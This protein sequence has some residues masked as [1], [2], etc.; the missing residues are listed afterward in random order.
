MMQQSVSVLGGTGFV[1]R[2]LINQ[3]V[4]KGYRV[5]VP[6]RRPYGH[7][8]LGVLSG[9]ELVDVDIHDR[10]A[11]EQL[12]QGQST[13]INLVGILNEHRD[14]T[15]KKVHVDL[16]KKIASACQEAGVKRLLH[17]SALQAN[18]RAPSQYL[19]TK[20]R[21]EDYLHTEAG[22]ELAVTS[23]RPSVIFGPEDS[24]LNRF[25]SLLKKVPWLFPLACPAA[26]FQPVYVGDVAQAFVTALQDRESYN[27]RIDLCGPHIYTLESLVAYT[28]ELLQLKRKIIPLPDWVART[29]ALTMGLMPGKPFSM[30]NYRSLQIDSVCRQ[31][32]TCPTALEAIAPTYLGQAGKQQVLQHYRR[33]AA[34]DIT[35]PH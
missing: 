1:G 13:V 31:G 5:K 28:A 9:V 11:L 20:G 2:Y 12:F 10:H 17:M 21:A 25:A 34:R 23:F 15:F 8:D 18:R 35:S 16:V 19:Q 30:D 32:G 27:K 14:M 7:R 26:R 33:H 29:Q 24:F 6:T 3:L 4:Q 22:S